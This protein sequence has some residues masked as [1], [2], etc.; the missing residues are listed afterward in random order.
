M[1]VSFGQGSKA[2]IPWIAFLKA[3]Q[4]VSNGIYPVY[5][6]YRKER[7]LILAY[8]VSEPKAPQKKWQLKELETIAGYF[9]KHGLGKPKHYGGSLIHKVYNLNE[10]LKKSEIDSDLRNILGVYHDV[11][12]G[13]SIKTLLSRRVFGVGT[14][15]KFDYRVFYEHCNQSGLIISEQLCVRFIASLLAKPFVILTGLSG[16]GKTKIALSF[17]KWICEDDSQ[18]CVIPVGADWTNREPLLGFSNALEKD[19][20]VFPDNGALRL[21]LEAAVKENRDKPYFLILDEMNLSHVER[22]FADFLSAM[23]SGEALALHDDPAQLR[24]SVPSQVKLPGN[25][26]IIGTVNVDETTYMFSPKVLDR[27]NVIEFRVTG[28]EMQE[29]LK[30]PHAPDAAALK[31]QGAGM[32]K[33][34]VEISQDRSQKLVSDKALTATLLGFFKPLQQASTEFGYRAASEIIRLVAAM[35]KLN[36]G[37]DPDA[38]IDVAIMQKLLPKVHGSRR[39]LDPVLDAMASICLRDGGDIQQFMINPPEDWSSQENIRYPISLEKIYR[40][41][42]GLVGNGFTSYTEA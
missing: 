27:A 10:A 25:L 20:Y 36:P 32:A 7:L 26:F 15:H 39:K 18:I 31:C 16:S 40:M 41:K 17:A 35:K 5:L 38:L 34:F 9:L 4:K 2:E 28:Q 21:L 6:L 42:T 30:D 8:G 22:Y 13:T 24:D 29:Y 23:E 11:F 37:L 33:D 14:Q 1:K 3:G 12:L 19:R